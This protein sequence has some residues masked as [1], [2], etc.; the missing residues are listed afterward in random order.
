MAHS[1]DQSGSH[2][3]PSGRVRRFFL[4]VAAGL[5]LFII[6]FGFTLVAGVN[7]FDESWFLQVLSRLSS[8]DILYRDVFFGITPLSVY[9]TYIPIRIFGVQILVVKAVMSLCFSLTV[10][11]CFHITRQLGL[12]RNRAFLLVGVL[13]VYAPPMPPARIRFSATFSCLRPSVQVLAGQK[14]R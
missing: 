11:L 12:V 10:L 3:N 2:L 14:S 7:V 8:G 6:G 4:W 13:P 9:L 5:A 1:R